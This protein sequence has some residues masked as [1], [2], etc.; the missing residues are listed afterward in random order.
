MAKDC[1]NK[2]SAFGGVKNC[3]YFCHVHFTCQ[4]IFKKECRN[5]KSIFGS[6]D[7]RNVEFGSCRTNCSEKP[8][9]RFNYYL[10][11]CVDVLFDT[12]YQNWSDDFLGRFFDPFDCRWALYALC[13]W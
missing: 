3:V 9:Y 4:I 6:F 11:E 13:F 10:Y 5:R 2:V 7:C 8:Q 12:E 1:G